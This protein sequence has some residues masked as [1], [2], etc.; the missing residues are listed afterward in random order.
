MPE[1]KKVKY[2]LKLTHDVAETFIR[3]KDVNYYVQ[4]YRPATD[5]IDYRVDTSYG[6]IYGSVP[7]VFLA[8][9]VRMKLDELRKI[10]EDVWPD[11]SDLVASRVMEMREMD[12][13]VK[14]TVTAVDIYDVTDHF[15]AGLKAALGRPT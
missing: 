13:A 11:L 8:V 3:A 7:I 4:E 10:L 5:L 9:E 2:V 6:V 12:R 14:D 1:E 15:V